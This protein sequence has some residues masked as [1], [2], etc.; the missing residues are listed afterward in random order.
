MDTKI[1]VG[2]ENIYFEMESKHEDHAEMCD[3]LV[4]SIKHL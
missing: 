4:V 1:E 3:D 2:R